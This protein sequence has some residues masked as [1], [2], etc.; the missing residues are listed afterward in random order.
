MQHDHNHASAHADH[1]CCGSASGV[2][3]DPDLTDP[4]CGMKVTRQS[5][6]RVAHAGTR[7]LF[8]QRRMR[9]E[10]FGRPRK[11]S[12]PAPARRLP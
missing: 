11:V 1:A 5:K 7:L 10:V 8:L 6:H 2:P 12:E 3:S 9:G 4:V